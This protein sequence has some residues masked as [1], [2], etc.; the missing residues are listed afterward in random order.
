[1]ATEAVGVDGTRV[2]DPRVWP[3]GLTKGDGG[4]YWDASTTEPARTSTALRGPASRAMLEATLT[5]CERRRSLPEYFAE[6]TD[7][8]G[9]GPQEAGVGSEPVRYPVSPRRLAAE[10]LGEVPGGREQ[11]HTQSVEVLERI[12]AVGP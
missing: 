7:H 10:L 2:G 8:V 12:A 9:P 11:G 6:T 1:M 5:G 4:R 3:V